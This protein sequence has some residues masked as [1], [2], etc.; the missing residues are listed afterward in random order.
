M[1]DTKFDIS[2]RRVFS[3]YRVNLSCQT[4]VLCSSSFE[5]DDLTANHSRIF[6]GRLRVAYFLGV[7]DTFINSLNE[8]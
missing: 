1:K 7:S 5:A 2:L 8:P 4:N 3:D 6:F